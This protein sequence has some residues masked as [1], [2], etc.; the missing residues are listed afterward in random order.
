MMTNNR[1]ARE[2]APTSVTRQDLQDGLFT[3]QHAAL[4][5]SAVCRDLSAGMSEDGAATLRRMIGNLQDTARSAETLRHAVS[6]R[7]SRW[8]DEMEGGDDE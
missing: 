5:L 6:D 4:S 7:C 2:T 1:Q 8:L 3:V